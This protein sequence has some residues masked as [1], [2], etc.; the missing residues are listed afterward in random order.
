MNY[1][2][3]QMCLKLIT[4]IPFYSMSMFGPKSLKHHCKENSKLSHL[5]QL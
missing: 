4:S 5:D 1:G 3:E 2:L